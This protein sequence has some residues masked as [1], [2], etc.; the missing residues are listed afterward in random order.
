MKK[1]LLLIVAF[2]TLFW[3]NIN[4]QTDPCGCTTT[5]TA[6]TY[7]YDTDLLDCDN[8]P[9]YIIIAYDLL[10]CGP[11]YGINFKSATVTEN[12]SC[13]PPPI[14]AV[15]ITILNLNTYYRLAQQEVLDL[16]P[17]GSI[18]YWVYPA[19]CYSISTIDWP[20]SACYTFPLEGPDTLIASDT[21]FLQDNAVSLLPCDGE[22]CC[23]LS[24][25][26]NIGTG[27]YVYLSRTS[28]IQCD[29]DMTDTIFKITCYDINKVPRTITGTIV[30]HDPCTSFCNET[31]NALIKTDRSDKDLSINQI[32]GKGKSING[33]MPLPD[34]FDFSIVPTRV[35]DQ[36]IFS[37]VSDIAKIEIFEITGKK[38]LEQNNFEN[39]VID[40]S[41]LKEGIYHIRIY[42]NNSG[43]RT[44]KILKD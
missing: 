4:A 15:Q 36:V 12:Y 2:V 33:F 16:Y 19:G 1:H 7:W 41:K 43:I 37:N 17:S 35:H 21:M 13:T 32:S 39:N 24:Y 42:F 14:Y 34:P 3:G 38:I 31:L 6:L 8:N 22:N 29:S 44:L 5:N 40:V 30:S 11:N 25:T 20:D 10:Q 26:F 9:I 18:M 28:D 23:T 27:M